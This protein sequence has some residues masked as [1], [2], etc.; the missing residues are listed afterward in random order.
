MPGDFGVEIGGAEN[1]VPPPAIM[2][3]PTRYERPHFAE[4][5]DKVRWDLLYKMRMA[6][7]AATGG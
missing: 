7:K 6:K 4:I 1:Y 5:P 3:D 2:T